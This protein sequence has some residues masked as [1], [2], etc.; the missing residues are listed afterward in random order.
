MIKKLMSARRFVAAGVLSLIGIVGVTNVSAQLF[1]I[2]FGGGAA[3]SAGAS[4]DPW[5]TFDNLVMDETV[6][7]GGGAT[8][9]ALDD[10]FNPN[11]PAQP[12]EG[13]EYDGESVPQEARN[14]YFF[15]ITDTAGTTARM[16]I[17]GLAAG[18]YNVTVFEGRTT[19][20]NQ[21]AKIWTGEEPEEENTGNFAQ[22]SATV[23]VNVGVGE[24]LWYMHLEDNTGGISGMIIRQTSGG[25][26]ELVPGLIAYWPFDSASDLVDKVAGIEGEAQGTVDDAE[27]HLG[28]A[29]DFGAGNTGNWIKVDAEATTWLAAA[30]DND[31]MSVSFWQKLHAVKSASTIWFRAEAAGSNARNFQAHL[32]WG[33]NSI[34]FDTGGCCDGG[35][36]RINKDASDIDFLEWHHFVFVKDGENKSIWVDGELFHEGVNTNALFDDWTY[37]AIGSSGVDVF[38]DAIVDDFGVWAR[39]ITEDEVAAIYNGGAGAPLISAGAAVPKPTV[40]SLVTNAGGFSF[41]VK[42]VDGA[43]AD[44]DSIVVTYDGAVVEVVKSKADGVTSVSYSLSE[45]LAPESVHTLNVALKDTNGNGSTIEKSFKVKAYS[46]IDPAIRVPDSMKGESGFLVYA[47]QIST[48]QGVGNLHGNSWRNAEK[49]IQGGYHNPDADEPYLNEADPDSFEGW[50]YYPEIVEVVNQNQDAPA[51]I[52]NFQANDKGNSTDREDEPITGIPGWGDSTDGIASEYLA[53]LELPAG[54]HT[55]GVNSDDGFSAS[56]AGN[57]LDMEQQQVGLFDGGRGAATSTFIVHV[58]EPGLYP[59]RVSWWEGGGGANIEIFSTVGKEKVLINDPDVEG[60]IKAWTPKGAVTDEQVT[61]RVGTGRAYISG[62]SPVDG[63]FAATKT[64]ELTVVNGS[65]STLDEGSVKFSYDGEEVTHSVV[66]DGDARA[67]TYDATSGG[68][69]KHTAL[70]EFADSDGNKRSVEWSFTLAEPLIPGMPN[71]IAFWDFNFNQNPASA[72]DHVNGRIGDVVGGVYI[73]DTPSGEEG[74]YAMDFKASGA[75]VNVIDGEFL[76]IVATVDQISVSFWQK[77]YSTPSTASFKGVSTGSS[78]RR[79]FFAHVPWSNGHIYWDTAGCCDGNSQRITADANDIGGWPGEALDQW[80]HY[81]FVKNGSE[82]SI[83]VDGE[84]FHEGTNTGPL[85]MDMTTLVIGADENGA[86]GVHGAI[87]DFA[88]FASALN[89]EQIVALAEGDRGILPKEPGYPL[90]ASVSPSGLATGEDA[91]QVTLVKRV[92]AIADTSLTVNGEAVDL[93]VAT[94]GNTTTLTGKSDPSKI[95]INSATVSFNGREHTWSYFNYGEPLKDDGENLIAHWDFESGTRDSVYGLEG[96]LLNDAALA[97]MDDRNVLDLSG[98]ASATMKVATADLLDLAATRDQVTVSLWQK[99]KSIGDTSSF[100]GDSPSSGSTRG[101]HAHAPWG[102]GA[103]YWDTVG[104]CNGSTQRINKDNPGFDYTQWHHYAFV[105]DKGKKSIWVDGQLFHEGNNSLALPMDMS[106]LWVGSTTDGGSSINGAID[107][108]KVFAQALTGGQI[109][110]QY[111]QGQAIVINITEQPASATATLDWDHVFTVKTAATADGEPLADSQLNYQWYLNGAAIDGANGSSFRT[112]LLSTAD[113]GGK[114]SVMINQGGVSLSSEEAVLAV[115]K[116]NTAPGLAVANASQPDLD[117]GGG[118][119]LRFNGG[120]NYVSVEADIVESDYTVEFWFRTED[121]NAG[122]YC[123]VDQNLGGGGHDRHLHLVGGNIRVR[124]WSGEGT[125]VST[126]LNLADGK[127]HHLAH[128]LGADAEGQKIYIDGEVVVEQSK[129]L[130]NF[131]WQKHLNFG[132]SN[133]AA[134]QYLVGEMDELRVWEVVRTEEEIKDNMNKTLTG[135]EDLLFAYYRFDEVSGEVLPDLLEGHDGVLMGMGD[136]NWVA[137]SA[138]LGQ[139]LLDG[140]PVP[141]TIQI[142]FNEAIRDPAF[143]SGGSLI[144]DGKGAHVA[145]PN[146]FP[147]AMSGLEAVT[148]EYWFKGSV[149]QSAVRWQDGPYFVAGWNGLHIISTDGGTGAGIQVGPAADGT[150]HHVAMTWEMDGLFTSYLDGELVE[151]R[152]AGF[153]PLP[154][155]SSMAYLGAYQGTSEFTDGKLDEVRVWSVARTQ[156]QL[157]Q[158]KDKSL[159]GGEEGLVA[160][161]KFDELVGNILPDSSGNGY[162]GQLRGMTDTNWSSGSNPS[163]TNV[164]PKGQAVP[165]VFEIEGAKVDSVEY[166]TDGRTVE[167]VAYDVGSTANVTINGVRDT[168]NNEIKANTS[169]EIKVNAGDVVFETEEPEI[170]AL[171]VVNNGDGT[172]TVTFEGKLEAAASVNGPWQ[173]SGLTSPATI[174]ADQAMQYAR[175]VNE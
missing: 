151:E 39:G 42:D 5:I 66:K 41:L 87:D 128:V 173:D 8:L 50:A 109:A 13:A 72:V 32:P 33:N 155:I 69:G 77:N 26:G 132:F 110:G 56:F 64:I 20:G 28:G 38:A 99:F 114:Y 18:T 22:G 101:F 12:G 115:A 11:N 65:V 164:G 83:W 159:G 16:R 169:F 78:H 131:D 107:D 170:P 160:Y 125:K 80:H 134:S 167:I 17:D 34:F 70:V 126:G 120:G 123:V 96:E 61:E 43:S 117:S 19:D 27:G 145:L 144:F 46:L 113:D 161:Y 3:N 149:F 37:L 143:G 90:L 165:G 130:S 68:N 158:W 30:S 51:G 29:V 147:Q 81:V 116:D 52:G 63:G 136:K 148:V 154:I 95:G 118:A 10:G 112:G 1:L 175:A 122:L 14:D 121:P 2:D 88:I 55:F 174:S 129:D 141:T 62:L 124:T 108:F 157:A 74:D 153:E 82:K 94:E 100:N 105:K 142:G 40:V 23:A 146:E 102:S 85:P 91:L 104:C 75:H 97:E 58:Q 36:Q 47:T 73:D 48:A 127:W 137:S 31:A 133:D 7:L 9:T 168:G 172:V 106:A 93:D 67:I 138:P 53:L 139:P 60:S 54:S 59:F 98:G 21:V 171:S 92:D 76:N 150:W 152:D 166:L 86:S 111:F 140:I 35:T 25:G 57:F 89:E 163:F 84:F 156:E 103:I 44:P 79:G 4:P 15:K 71:P 135:D 24:P 45:L 162:H 119:A 49:Q 6:D